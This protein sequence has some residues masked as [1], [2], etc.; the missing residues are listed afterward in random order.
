MAIAIATWLMAEDAAKKAK[1]L[2]ASNADK[3]L[4]KLIRG[5]EEDRSLI[6]VGAGGLPNS[7]GEVE[8]DAAFMDGDTLKYGAVAGLK[9][10]VS[11]VSIAYSLKDLP[12]NNFLVGE[13]A[14]RFALAQGFK[15]E[16]L[17]TDLSTRRYKEHKSDNKLTA[18]Q[19]HDTIGAIA[20]DDS[21]HMVAAASTSGLFYKHPGRVGD[22]PIIGSG[23]YVDSEVGGACAT[24]VGEDIIKS[25][26]SYAIVSLMKMGLSPKEA[27]HKALSDFME[28]VVRSNQK[29]RDISVIAIDKIGRYGAA[30]NIDSFSFVIIKDGDVKVKRIIG[31]DYVDVDEYFKRS[32]LAKERG[33]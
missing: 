18:Y 3:A 26:I 8:L 1:D 24:G 22:S 15:E 14:K 33:E 20:L 17:S 12:A 16:D 28:R 13:G 29:L 32:W 7:D 5:V 6:S 23:L 31:G 10:F 30:S 25:C 19:G 11:P 21:G 2:L 9:G 4:L 27:C